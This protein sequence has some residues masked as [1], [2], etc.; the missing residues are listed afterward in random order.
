MNHLAHLSLAADHQALVV[1]GYLGDF[2]RGRLHNLPYETPIR[3]G[4]ALHRHIDRVTDHHPVVVELR[5]TFED[6][7]RRY[8][9][10]MLDMA[11]DHLL[12]RD[13]L[14]YAATLQAPGKTAAVAPAAELDHFNATLL[15]TLEQHRPQ[16]ND[17]ARRFLDYCQRRQLFAAYR[18]PREIERSLLGIGRRLRRDNPLHR[19]GAVLWPRLPLIEQRF[20]LL[21][22]DLVAEVR[23]WQHQQGWLSAPRSERQSGSW[24]GL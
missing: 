8:A 11:F 18:Q 23:R 17:P 20:P 3:A 2:V 12:A 19:A 4:V 14:D 24:S 10:I 5:G 13:W 15:Q 16:L 21:W 6:G 7:W 22:R 1:G 9:G